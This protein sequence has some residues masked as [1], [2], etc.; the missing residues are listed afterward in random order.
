MAKDVDIDK[1][2]ESLEGYTGA[3]IQGICEEAT[4]LTI[5]K[6]LADNS[7]NTKDPESVKKVKISKKEFD[8][9]MEKVLKSAD[10]AK[11]AQDRYAKEPEEMYR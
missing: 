10:R 1:M 6:A 8:E 9:S 11:V 5:R 2:A 3:D 4:L 7:I